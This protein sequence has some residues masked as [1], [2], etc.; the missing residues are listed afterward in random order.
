MSPVTAATIAALIAGLAGT[1]QATVLGLLGRRIGI[2]AA[3]AMNGLVAASLLAAVAFSF[4]RATEGIPAAFR[5]PVWVWIIPGIMGALVV[6]ALAFAPPR[7]GTFGTFALVIG[8]QLAAAFL[9]DSLG[10]FGLDRVPLSITRVAGLVLLASG[11]L[12][13]LRR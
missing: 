10:L 12:L 6:T 7:I 9:I 3:A 1:V 13:A 2:L 4:G 11:A 5:Q 8:G